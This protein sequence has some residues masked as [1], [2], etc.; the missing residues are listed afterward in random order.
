[1][2]LLSNLILICRT[3]TIIEAATKISIG[4]YDEAFA[5]SLT[6]LRLKPETI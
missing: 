2:I 3:S 1:M 6:A 5:D 4:R